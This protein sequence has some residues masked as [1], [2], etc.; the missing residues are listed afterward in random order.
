MKRD[1]QI[2]LADALQGGASAEKLQTL[3]REIVRDEI[4][5]DGT[6]KGIND[7]LT[8]LCGH[9]DF[10]IRT[11]EVAA[12][13]PQA[14]TLNAER[15]KEV[16][17]YVG[18]ALGYALFYRISDS[19]LLGGIACV[20][21]G[22]LCGFALKRA[23]KPQTALPATVET[24]I[25]STPREVEAKV[26][27]VAGQMRQLKDMLCAPRPAEDDYPLETKYPRVLEFLNNR[28]RDCLA[29]KNPDLNVKFGIEDIFKLYGYELVEYDGNNMQYFT[30][31]QSRMQEPYKTTFP[32]LLNAETRKCIFTGH[33]LFPKQDKQ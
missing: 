13:Q 12:R 22:C 30:S 7:F 32:A 29:Q 14:E 20:G 15:V 3:C 4:S 19:H 6:E 5:L 31:S 33:V 27:A 26:D 28:Y 11:K 18:G 24:R 8:N 25:V 16:L 10:G 1:N 2:K 21:L 9:L 23:Q 17:G